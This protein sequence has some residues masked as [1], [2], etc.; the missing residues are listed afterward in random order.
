[1]PDHVALVETPRD[2]FQGLPGFIPTAEKI[3]YL[4]ALLETG[5]RHVEVG[6]FV[7]PKAIPQMADTEAVVRAL[8]PREEIEYIGLIVNEQG[9]E[10]ALGVG[11]LDTLGFPFS[12]S[13]EFQVRNTKKSVSE[14]WPLVERLLARTESHDMSFLVY[15]SMAFGNPYGEAWSEAALMEMLRSLVRLGVRHVALSDTCAAA[16]PGQARGVFARAAKEFPVLELSAHFHG[17]PGDWHEVVLAALEAGCRRFDGAAG[18]MGGCPFAADKLISN[19]PT[20]GL[21]ER[22]EALGHKT[23]VDPLKLAVCARMARDLQA[24]YG[25]TH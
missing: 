6:S 3:A 21:V 12:L 24:K 13:N 1:M 8:P 10:R 17:R 18:G 23:G 5:L 19:V 14:T 9:V 25:K 20:E 7:S 22:F 15:V 16:E 11:G 4:R 2:A